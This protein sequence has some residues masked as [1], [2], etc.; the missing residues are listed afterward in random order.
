MPPKK[1]WSI[2]ELIERDESR[3]L[4]AESKLHDAEETIAND[5][6][7]EQRLTDATAQLQDVAT[8]LR[9]RASALKQTKSA[10]I[11]LSRLQSFGKEKS[12]LQQDERAV[13]NLDEAGAA[14]HEHSFEQPT[15]AKLETVVRTAVKVLRAHLLQHWSA[16]SS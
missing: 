16:V 2:D 4:D 1:Q 9:A 3:A 5:G 8:K 7:K 13:R 12:L 11:A 15:A 10:A 14:L 6:I